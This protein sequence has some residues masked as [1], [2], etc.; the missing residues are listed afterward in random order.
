M[1]VRE[2]TTASSDKPDMQQHVDEEL[3]AAAPNQRNWRGIILALLVITF[4][5]SMIVVSAIMLTPKDTRTPVTGRRFTLED[6]VGTDFKIN[7][8]NGS[9]LSDH[10]LVYRD[11]WGGLSVLDCESLAT[12]TLVSNVTFRQHNV[13]HF[14][15]SSDQQ[16]VLLAHNVR[17]KFRHSYIA[18]YTVYDIARG[19]RHCEASARFRGVLPVLRTTPHR[20]E[21]VAAAPNQRN[22]RGIILALLVITFIFSMIVV[23]AIMLTPKDTRTPVTDAASL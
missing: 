21:L 14:W 22:W 7:A 15:V 12:R 18:Q 19:H 8:F 20:T 10:E 4:I 3:V 17:Q 13:R 5:F 1:T 6:V 9:W 11:M 23:S 2:P 16:Y